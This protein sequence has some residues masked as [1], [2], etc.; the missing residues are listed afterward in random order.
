M[1]KGIFDAKIY[2]LD[3]GINLISIKRDTQIASLHIGFKV[4]SL[5]EKANERGIS[6]FIEHMLFKGTKTRDNENINDALEKRGGEYNAYTDYTCTVYNITALCEEL[7]SSIEILADMVQNS[8]FPESEIEKERGVI[9]AEIRTSKDDI[10]DYSFNKINQAAFSKSPLRYD[11]LGEE[12]TVKK[13]T[14]KQ[15][16]DFYSKYYI[17]NNCFITI[18]S[19]YE[20]HE[21]INLIE[22]YFNNW[23]RK[24]LNIESVVVENNIPGKTITYKKDIEQSTIIYAFTFHG[25]NKK[26]ELALKILNHKFGESANS[27]LFRELREERGLAYDIYSH[28]DM[29]NFVKILYIYT[30]VE[31]QNVDEAISVIDECIKKIISEDINFNEDTVNLMKKVL[32]TAVAATLEDSTDLGNYCLHQKLEEE[33]IYEFLEDMKNL[34]YIKKEDI[35]NVARKVFKNATIHILTPNDKQL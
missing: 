26:E 13:F 11:T 7:E 22:V 18:V 19:P 10:E 12:K 2:N 4:G 6:H 5:Y 25:L 3:N 32:K 34:Q 24:E 31:P 21:I 20:H 15:L 35:Y 9:L 33:S 23:E 29:T 17:P 8:I 28:I 30:A 16:M 14:R 27:I 1:E